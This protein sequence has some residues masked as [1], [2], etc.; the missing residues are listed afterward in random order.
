MNKKILLILT[1]LVM[2]VIFAF[3]L[4]QC[5]TGDPSRSANL[6]APDFSL[7]DLNGNTVRLSTQK[8]NPVILFFGTT[9][10]PA[11]RQEIPAIKNIHE[12]YSRQGL[13]LYYIDI[14]E[15]AERVKR[16]AN[17]N[18]LPYTILMDSDGGVAG[19]Y[20]IIG[21]PTFI[22]IDK[23]GSIISVVHRT[24]DLSLESLSP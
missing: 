18:A 8:G 20:N 1:V 5:R 17:Q 21:V 16:F 4:G 13:R 12:K 3:S 2:G 22:L 24:S 7:K 14:N 19:R 11:C 6:S 9:W 10:C 23:E 15:T